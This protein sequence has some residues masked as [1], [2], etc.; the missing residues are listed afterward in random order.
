MKP[1]DFS[2]VEAILRDIA[3]HIQFSPVRGLFSPDQVTAGFEI[4]RLD[5][6]EAKK[7]YK[8]EPDHV[9]IELVCVRVQG[10]P[11][12]HQFAEAGF[13]FL[14]PEH[15]Y[16]SLE[17]K[18][19]AFGDWNRNEESVLS[20]YNLAPGL[21]V[22]VPAKLVHGFVL[23]SD[24]P[25]WFLGVHSPLIHENGDLEV[26]PY[27]LSEDEPKDYNQKLLKI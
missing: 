11:H 2:R 16:E 8:V 24:T 21:I 7:V 26:V 27:I 10:E 6:I 4:Y 17:N 5:P 22:K 15:G 18:Y 19:V 1:I 14:G 25:L 9:R 13:L 3:S 23:R 12:I 20:L